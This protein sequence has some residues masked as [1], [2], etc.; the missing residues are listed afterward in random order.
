[1]KK[2]LNVLES[3]VRERKKDLW[4]SYEL[5][6]QKAI[7]SDDEMWLDSNANLVDELKLEVIKVL[8]QAMD[9]EQGVEMLNDTVLRRKELYGNCGKQLLHPSNMLDHVTACGYALYFPLFTS[10]SLY[11]PRTIS[12]G[13]YS[14]S[15]PM[16]SYCC[17]SITLLFSLSIVLIYR[18]LLFSISGPHCPYSI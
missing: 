16:H 5:S 13:P 1:L 14:L 15:V 4:L 11:L 6:A 18:F 12:S 17:T 10:I 2:G 8:E 9:Y 3:Q 7:S